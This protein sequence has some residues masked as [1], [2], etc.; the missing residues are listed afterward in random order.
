MRQYLSV[1]RRFAALTVIFF[2]PCGIVAKAE[3]PQAEKVFY[4]YVD[5]QGQLS[6]GMLEMP[7]AKPE[8]AQKGIGP[9]PRGAS[10]DNRVDIV[11]VGDGYTA[12][13]QN[14]FHTHANNALATMFNQQPFAMYSPLFQT[15]Q[16]EVIS[17]QSGVD[18][19]PTQGISRD[20]ALDMGFW[21]NGTDRLLCVDVAKAFNAALAAPDVDLILAVANSTTYGGA[22]YTAS[23]LATA[24]GGNGAAA[25][26]AIHEFGHSLG[27]LADEYDYGGP[28]TYAG[29][30]P[31][32]PNV[33][34]LNAAAMQS[35]GAKWNL[36]LGLNDAAYDGLV[37]TFEGANYSQFGIY[38]PSND[39]KMRSLGR[40]FNHPSAEAIIIEIYKI[41]KP[42]DNSTPTGTT[43]NGNETV[44]VDPIDPVSNPLQITWKLDGNVIAGATGTTLNLSTQ[45]IP[46]GAHT[47][48]VVVKDTTTLVRNET[49]RN[50]WMTQTLNWNLLVGNEP[51]G[52]APPS[53]NPMTFADPPHGI[54]ATEMS[55]TATTGTD[56]SPPVEYEFDFTSGA[57]GGAD[58]G[59]Q[60]SETYVNAGLTANSSYT[61][62]VRARDSHQLQNTGQYSNSVT[63][64]TLIQT[65][66]GVS[67][68]TVTAN[69]IVLNAGGTFSFLALQSSGIYFDS[70]TAGGDGGINEW[71][72]STTDTATGLSANTTYTFQAKG[73]NR[74]G[75]ETP[76]GPSGSKTTLA[77]VPTVPVLSAA[78]GN[79]VQIDPS[80][81]ANPADTE[82]A[83]QCVASSPS[84]ANW[85]LMY[86][87]ATGAT[88][89]SAVWQ[90][91]A[92]WGT[93]SA[94]GMAADTQYTFAVKA[95]NFDLIET[96]FGTS[97]SLT[98]SSAP[99]CSLLG[100]VNA[101]GLRNGDD[102]AAFVRA[103][104]SASLPGENAACADYQTGTLDG[105]AAAFVADL[106]GS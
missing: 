23:D 9:E 54:S 58:R 73:R 31:T 4:D 86:V 27:N 96:A 39:S 30:E 42:I 7:F 33:S 32:D 64:Y 34:K 101:D 76:Y 65:P 66:T 17:N 40:P 45:S 84:D 95:R 99:T 82:L 10:T 63:G 57:A 35:A 69:S 75:G 21:C 24:S 47:L 83:I 88:S 46:S 70:I 38:R 105:D 89:S 5:E 74:V 6:G 81:G 90:T 37:S 29:S 52:L 100:D 92:N 78:T 15:H 93:I 72:H 51:G 36:W 12:G 79:S 102:V 18:N 3:A 71:L 67:F 87:G 91:D 56:A 19:D 43:L 68:G 22:G 16:V 48:S 49:A 50:T 1:S 13:Q 62:R 104:T 77:D 60:T 61:Y 28:A 2:I 80:P 103:K 41:V 26:I 85:T 20:T 44:F 25:E 94:T 8:W 98:T 11:V 14:T 53:P 59:F 55:M 97:S 106:I